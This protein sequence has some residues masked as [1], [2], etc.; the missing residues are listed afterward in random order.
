MNIRTATMEDAEAIALLHAESWRSAYRGMF[1]EE[2]L[3][4]YVVEDRK[5]IWHQRFAA[6][7]NNQIVL[8][9]E[10]DPELCGFACAFGNEDKN[11]V[12]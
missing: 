12:Y 10:E 11:G 8:V 1:K 9:A 3:D 2:F 5:D 4:R 6:P 7:Q